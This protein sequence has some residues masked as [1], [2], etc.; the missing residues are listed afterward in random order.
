VTAL[1]C[2]SE[3]TLGAGVEYLQYK[4]IQILSRSLPRLAGYWVSDRISDLFY[5]RDKCSRPAIKSNLRRILTFK[6]EHPSEEELERL[7]RLVFHGYGRNLIDF[8]YFRRFTP[9]V[10]RRLFRIEG[11]Q[12]LEQAQA[13][14]K[15]AI[16]VSAHFGCF[17]LAASVTSLLLSPTAFHVVIQPLLDSRAEALFTRQRVRCGLT[18]I[19]MGD[20]ARR[21][22]EVL[23]NREVLA[24]NCDFDFSLHD[25]RIRFLDGPV[26]LPFGPARLAVRTGAPILPG[27]VTR[28]PDGG[29][30]MRYYPL[31]IPEKGMPVE[32]VQ[33]QVVKVLESAVLENPH[34]WF[35]FSDVWDT[36]WNLEIARQGSSSA[37]DA[38]KK[39]LDSAAGRR[40]AMGTGVRPEDF[41]QQQ[42]DSPS[43]E[44]TDHE[45]DPPGQVAPENDDVKSGGGNK[46]GRRASISGR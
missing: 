46:S 7:V 23:R 20:A 39:K 4:A 33:E 21:C 3:D 8:F 5:W 41:P 42:V 29:Y 2:L 30:L 19:R 13:L 43:S 18:L 22:L 34:C 11:L 1:F 10:I 44:H 45:P 26:R 24:L 32:R 12:Y 27:F 17:D 15:G 38:A 36:A 37:L 16:A 35:L 25:D 40:A 28:R 9:R 6:G 14:G 31:I